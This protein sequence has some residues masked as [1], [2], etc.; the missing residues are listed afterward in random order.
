LKMSAKANDK[1][2]SRNPRGDLTLG[3]V[4]QHLFRL[5]FPMALGI[6]ALVS[7]QLV[8]TWYIAQLGTKE[9]AAFSFTFPVTMLVFHLILG[10]SIAISSVVS[11]LIGEGLF[12]DVRR[13][14]THA[15]MLVAIVASMIGVTGYLLHDHIFRAIGADASM[16]ELISQYMVPWFLGLVLVSLPVVTNGAFRAHGDSLTPTVIMIASAV[17]NALIAPVMI[18]GLL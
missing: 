16:K 4:R 6:T 2:F 12:D 18:F 3:S 5:S 7:F 13:V 17:A 1:S 14:I 15:M 8:D 11:R 9:L 10:F